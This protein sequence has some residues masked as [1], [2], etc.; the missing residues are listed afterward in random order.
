MEQ[1]ELTLMELQAQMQG[2]SYDPLEV[3]RQ[4]QRKSPFLQAIETKAEELDVARQREWNRELIEDGRHPLI[5]KVATRPPVD[6]KFVTQP[7]AMI[8]P[9]GGG[10]TRA[11]TLPE[12]GAERKKYP[13]ATGLF[14]YFP[15]ALVAV[16]HLSWKA[17]EQ[18]NPGEPVHWARGKSADHD[19]T[20]LRHFAQRGTIDND[21]IRHR[22]K[23]AWRAL[24]ALQEELEAAQ[25]EEAA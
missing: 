5:G 22:T 9:Q 14:D 2:P 21:N 10:P 13:L 12:D 24:A 16:A 20:L 18:H 7:N 15:D 23:V 17:N 1:N 8:H 4:R 11:T 6:P 19:D 3:I 25:R